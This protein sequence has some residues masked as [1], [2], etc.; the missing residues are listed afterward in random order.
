[1]I[2]PNTSDLEA[3][4]EIE[5]FAKKRGTEDAV[6]VAGG[7]VRDAIH[8]DHVNYS[9]IDVFIAPDVAPTTDVATTWAQFVAIHGYKKLSDEAVY[10]C[11]DFVVC[12]HPLA[13]VQLIFAKNKRK[14][15]SWD[16]WIERTFDYSCDMVFM[17]I[18]LKTINK[19]SKWKRCNALNIIE[20]YSDNIISNHPSPQAVKNSLSSRLAKRKHLFPKQEVLLV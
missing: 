20:C 6:I 14:S 19:T 5:D 9:D 4:A 17:D 1:M 18:S 2:D 8:P 13:K 7:F 15:E 16:E 3:L 10:S 12:Q 11:S